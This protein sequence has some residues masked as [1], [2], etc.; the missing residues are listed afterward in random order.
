[1]LECS[2][3]EWD[4]I[5]PMLLFPKPQANSFAEQV[6]DLSFQANGFHLLFVHTDADA[7]SENKKAF[8]NK[9]NP[10]LD[11]VQNALPSEKYC[12]EI[13]PVI[14]VVKIEN[15]KLADTNSLREALATDL[16][17]NALG[18][19]IGARQLEEKSAS[20]ELLEEVIKKAN[21]NRRM[22]IRLEDLDAALAKNISLK[23]IHR[24]KSF[25]KFVERLK[26][27]LVQQNIIKAD[28]TPSF[29][30]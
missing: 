10:A 8:P 4:I 7:D 22:P 24:Y 19:N 17:D 16:E 15:W 18:L 29:T 5:E 21:H 1:M 13:V 23:K 3:G 20:K 28:C 11:A 25:Q 6:K 2:D 9:I 14:P 12:H 27:S 30:H 26:S